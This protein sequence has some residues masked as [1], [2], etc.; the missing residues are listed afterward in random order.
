MMAQIQ[1]VKKYY[2]GAKEY[3]DNCLRIAP[4]NKDAPEMK[5]NLVDKSDNSD[6][7]K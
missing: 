5:E 2:V 7:D 3:N 6:L 4:N 1:L